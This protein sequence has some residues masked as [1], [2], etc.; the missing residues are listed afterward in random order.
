MIV[1]VTLPLIFG[2]SVFNLPNYPTV[3][4]QIHKYNVLI[5]SPLT[6]VLWPIFGSAHLTGTYLMVLLAYERYVAICQKQII[7][8]E[9]T[10]KYILC[11]MIICIIFKIPFC[12]QFEWANET[13]GS[14]NFTRN[15]TIA[16]RT[17]LLN[18]HSLLYFPIYCLGAHLIFS[19]AIPIFCFVLFNCLMI[20]EV[21]I[22]TLLNNEW[23]VHHL[24]L[25]TYGLKMTLEARI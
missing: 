23:F 22:N 24:P 7:S 11:V 19:F 21:S 14:G 9:K 2:I 3:D 10:K 13:F 25:M 15:F 16:K 4:E 6:P 18:N 17:E 5:P 20:K 12:W 8:M 1:V